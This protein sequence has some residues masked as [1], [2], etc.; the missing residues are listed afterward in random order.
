[1]AAIE[2]YRQI[3]K[4]LLTKY[5]QIPTSESGIKNQIL[6]DKVKFCVETGFVSNMSKK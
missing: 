3:I 5:A 6:F 2:N 4:Q 1:M